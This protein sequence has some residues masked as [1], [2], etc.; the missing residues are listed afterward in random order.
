MEDNQQ[1]DA[2]FDEWSQDTNLR[3]APRNAPNN[4]QNGGTSNAQGQNA[5][6]GQASGN[7]QSYPP[8]QQQQNY[9][10]G[11]QSNQSN[12]GGMG[13]TGGGGAGQSSYG[14]GG[15]NTYNAPAGGSR[16]GGGYSGPK[17]Q[18][19]QKEI[20]PLNVELPYTL[21][22]DKATPDDVL[23]TMEGCLRDMQDRGFTLRWHAPDKTAPHQ[24]RITDVITKK[25]IVLPWKDFDKINGDYWTNRQGKQLASKLIFG[26]DKLPDNVKSI[27]AHNVHHVLGKFC[28]V[29]SRCLLTWTPDGCE[30]G[31]TKGRE[32]GYTGT[33]IRIC[34]IYNIPIFNFQRSNARQRLTWWLDEFERPFD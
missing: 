11:G 8:Q 20:K 17:G 31:K 14:N 16:P 15:S 9:P 22:M 19:P 27:V 34:S 7:N 30:T 21:H 6:V 2:I 28:S 5:P 33:I 32:T 26:Y 24:T 18:Y 13:G 23:R 1:P 12:A 4:Q 25:E 3:Q 29:P 10:Q